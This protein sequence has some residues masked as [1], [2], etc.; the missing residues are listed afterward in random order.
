MSYKSF[1]GFYDDFTQDVGYKERADYMLALFSRFDLIPTLLLD[2]G[3]GTG[4]F[5]YQFAENDIEVIGVDPSAE[6][7][8]LASSRETNA[9]KLPIFLCQSAQNLDLYGTVNGVVA[10]LDTVNHIVD[11]KELERSFQRI[12]LFLE[13][14]RLFIFDANTFYKHKKVLSGKKF[15]YDNGEKLCIWKNSRCSRNGTIKMKLKLYENTPE[16]YVRYTDSHSERAYTN[17]E[18]ENALKIAG[19]ELLGVFGDLSFEAPR[20]NEERCYFVA[21]KVK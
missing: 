8:S 2:V 4:G 1:A 17:L 6:M 11:L 12:S 5:S 9:E 10:C 18:L 20:E 16:G 3:C 13:P 21:K 19:F 14:E 15:I 7:L